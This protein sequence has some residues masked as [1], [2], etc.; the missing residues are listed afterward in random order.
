MNEPALQ[1]SHC[2]IED[3]PRQTEISLLH[4]GGKAF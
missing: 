2:F 1:I 4:A 3:R